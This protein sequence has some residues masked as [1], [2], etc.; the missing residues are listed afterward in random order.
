MK[1]SKL[2]K[3]E[4]SVFV[5]GDF[6]CSHRVGLTPPAWQWKTDAN[7]IEDLES[8]HQQ[9]KYGRIQAECWKTYKT[10]LKQTGPFDVAFLMGDLID[11]TGERSGGTELITTDRDVQ[12]DMAIQCVQ[13]LGAPIIVGVRGT[14]YHTGDSEDWED[15]VYSYFNARS[16][17]RAKVGDHEWP[18]INGVT[19]DLKHQVGSSA[20]P[21]G[22]WTALGK[23]WLWN[24]LWADAGYS[25]Q[26]DYIFRG[27]VHTAIGGWRFVGKRRVEVA[28]T[29]ALQAMGSKFGARRCSRLVDWGFYVLRITVKG[30]VSLEPHVIQIDSQKAK[31]TDL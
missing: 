25:P 18:R 30:N 11:G 27:H 13:E 4:I 12:R 10:L 8:V 16:G 24:Q 23:E 5:G 7:E 22:S 21:H 29:P 31:T 6:H 3:R 9:H 28:S 19:F 2:P 26:A 17:Y 20:V 15:Q 14:P 1:I